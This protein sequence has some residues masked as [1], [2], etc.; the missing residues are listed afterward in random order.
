MFSRT[1]DSDESTIV[2][3][4]LL[5]I[6]NFIRKPS[7]VNGRIIK[8]Y[9]KNLLLPIYYYLILDMYVRNFNNIPNE[10]KCSSTSMKKLNGYTF[11]KVYIF[12]FVQ[13]A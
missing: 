10:R 8:W 1:L 2:Y 11:E 4:W 7:F 13:S 12:L 6:T 3:K 9:Q 5:N